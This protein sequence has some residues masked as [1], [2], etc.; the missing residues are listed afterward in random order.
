MSD[1][2]YSSSTYKYDEDAIRQRLVEWMNRI[3]E[4]EKLPFDRVDAQIEIKLPS[5]GSRRYPDIVIWEK[6]LQ[7]P[8]C[9]IE[10]KQPYWSPFDWS[11]ISDAQDKAMKGSPQIPYF[12]TWNVNDLVLWKTFEEGAL[13]F[14]ERRK[15]IYSFAEIRDL[16]EI[17]YPEVEN[18]IKEQL[19]VFLRDLAEIAF[20]R[21]LLPRIPVDE[22]FIYSLRRVIDTFYQ[23][24]AIEIKR[25]IERKPSLKI[26]QEAS[27]LKW[28]SRNILS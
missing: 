12:A 6:R 14:E 4:E 24:V 8:I 10:L 26:Y 17:D 2:Y 19:R 25:E 15:G 16:R 18:R 9:I 1:P 13:S 5:G 28:S 21:K 22:Y 20:K 27:S 11:V 3:I 7:K 23:D